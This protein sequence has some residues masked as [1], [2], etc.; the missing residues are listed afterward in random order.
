MPKPLSDGQQRLVFGVLVLILIVFGVYLMLGG[1]DGGDTAEEQQGDENTTSESAQQQEAATPVPIP[2][3]ALEDANV[4]DW[5]P[6]DEQEFRAA[7]AVAQSFAVAYG[8]VDYS[9]TP[10][11]YY[12]RLE[13]FAT[14]DY[15]KSLARNSGASALWGEMSEKE[16]VA[17][18]SANIDSVR[19]F[20]DSSIVFLINAQSITQ[21]EDG[22]QQD[23]GEFAITMVQ[24]GG[25]WKV[26]D[27][28]PADAGNFGDP[29]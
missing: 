3:T 5:F 15:A 25:E 22:S 6:F 27:F 14:E 2:T 8:T 13:E 4:M 23:L 20:D 19:S 24:N 29:Q 17:E 16:A 28:Q 26:Y 21:D 7:A 9:K 10:E 1:F 11:D 12:D 18:G